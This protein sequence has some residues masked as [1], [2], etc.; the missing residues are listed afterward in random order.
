MI[1]LANHI[2]G[3]NLSL[4]IAIDKLGVMLKKDT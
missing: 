1:C 3:A 2:L 4:S